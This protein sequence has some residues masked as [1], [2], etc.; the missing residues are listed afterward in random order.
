MNTEEYSERM[1]T[2]KGRRQLLKNKLKEVVRQV[3]ENAFDDLRRRVRDGE[4]TRFSEKLIDQYEFETA[5]NRDQR[6]EAVARFK[7]EN[8]LPE[9]YVI[10]EDDYRELY[11][12]VKAISAITEDRP[13]FSEGGLVDD[14]LALSETAEEMDP[15]TRRQA[16]EEYLKQM[17]EL[18]LDL[19]P[20]TG[21]IRSAQ[22]AVEDF[23]EGNYGMAALGALGAVPGVGMVA[24]GAK[25]GVKAVSKYAD[26]LWD[27]PTQKI[28]SADTSINQNKLP[29]GYSKLKKLG[30]F[31]P[32]QRV[33]D[34]GGGRF[35]NAV[36][37]LA[38]KDVE[39]HVY[40]PFNR[41]PEHNQAVKELV[42]DGGADIALSNNV[43]NVIEEPENIKRVIQQAENAIKPGD[44]AYFTVYVGNKSGKGSSTSKGFQR[45]EPTP[46]YVPRVE[47]VFGK[48]NVERKGDVII[49]TK[50]TDTPPPATKADAPKER[51]FKNEK[52][53]TFKRG[54]KKYPVGKVVGNQVYFHKNYLDD[55]PK[56]AQD[57]YYKALEK[58][59]ED[60]S[61][62][63]LMY[64]PASKG[65][66]ARIRFDESTDFDVA[67]EPT[68]GK[69]ISI[70]DAGNV[71]S[72]KTDQIFH[73]KWMWVADD[74]PGFDVDNSYNWSKQ[75]AQT[76]NKAPSGYKNKWEQELKDAGLPLEDTANMNR[77]GLM[78]RK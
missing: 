36:E 27:V 76:L 70:D 16:G 50:N 17:T 39:L 22:G 56:E 40:D 11:Q 66:P 35:D 21:E 73:H 24:R 42:A 69:Y 19:A 18:G 51:T 71:K 62:N 41:A 72:G 6:E 30:V 14:P 44:K 46:A 7:D 12:Y 63:T 32:G 53:T 1:R 57:L 47:E 60:H 68:P 67:R 59:P 23:E 37:D 13:Q 10:K 25:A 3:S 29:A 20:G 58:L 4:E 15:E 49:A 5:G 45:N 54:N 28:T 8:N 55:M 78:A 38:K 33:V 77:G 43:L 48:G 74:Y 61:F 26:D 52:G 64:E 9:D 2:D 31:K 65:K 75:W 34:I